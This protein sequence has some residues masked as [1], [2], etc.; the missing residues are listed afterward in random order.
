MSEP[1]YKSTSK[2]HHLKVF[3]EP[4]PRRFRLEFYPV[5]EPDV[6][7]ATSYCDADYEPVAGIDVSDMV[8]ILNLADT[9][10]DDLI[11]FETVDARRALEEGE[12]NP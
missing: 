11:F 6:R 9:T 4:E 5:D 12:D 8:T 1:L 3:Y 10:E 2:Y 7:V